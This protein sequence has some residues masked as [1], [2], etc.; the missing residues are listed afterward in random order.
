MKTNEAEQVQ[1]YRELVE[2]LI[3]ESETRRTRIRA[4]ARPPRK[5]LQ[6]KH[7]QERQQ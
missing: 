7:K 2:Y 6:K 5:M 3:D 4:M 1:R